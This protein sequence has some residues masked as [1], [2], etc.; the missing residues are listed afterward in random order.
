MITIFKGFMSEL[1]SARKHAM[2]GEMLCLVKIFAY[3]KTGHGRSSDA[4]AL[5]KLHQSQFNEDVKS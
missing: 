4:Q 3:S 5:L 2:R 1:E